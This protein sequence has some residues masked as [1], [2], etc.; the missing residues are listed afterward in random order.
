MEMV[1]AAMGPFQRPARWPTHAWNQRTFTIARKSSVTF[2]T[3]ADRMNVYRGPFLTSAH[4][5]PNLRTVNPHSN[6]SLRSSLSTSL[7]C[8][9]AGL[10]YHTLSRCLSRQDQAPAAIPHSKFPQHT[11][12]F[13]HHFDP[14]SPPLFE[15]KNPPPMFYSYCTSSTICHFSFESKFPKTKIS[16]N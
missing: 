3:F 6:E 13:C 15:H 10:L 9:L 7:L 16:A 2:N 8:P 11:H 14:Q 12:T 4:A 5:K 1:L